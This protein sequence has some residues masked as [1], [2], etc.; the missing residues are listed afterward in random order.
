MTDS[1]KKFL[2]ITL[3][4]LCVGIGVVGI[5]VPGLPTTV[6]LIA[7]SYLYARSSPRR[8]QWLR[9]HRVLGSYLVAIERREM[10]ARVKAVT[11]IFLW[12]TIGVSVY[13][14]PGDETWGVVL[15]PCLLA[16][17]VGVSVYL[18]RFI[19]TATPTAL[20]EK[21]SVAENHP[22]SR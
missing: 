21:P 3:G 18:L 5:F 11:L 2:F 22:A 17:A 15:R 16:V 7:A 1:M 19:R 9:E 20:P 10:S 13:M 4:S 8:Y 14:L 12:G 6:F